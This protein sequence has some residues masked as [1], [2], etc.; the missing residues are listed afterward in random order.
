LLP[1]LAYMQFVGLA[2]SNYVFQVS[3][4]LSLW[5]P[6]VTNFS[7]VGIINFYDPYNPGVPNRFYRART[8]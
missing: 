2:N 5:V 8:Q 7:P 6:L 3:T 4:D 1:G